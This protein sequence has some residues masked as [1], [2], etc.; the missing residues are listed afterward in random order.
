MQ[1]SP[2]RRLRGRWLNWV[3]R[4]PERTL[5]PAREAGVSGDRACASEVSERSTGA[6]RRSLSGPPDH[7]RL[8]DAAEHGLAPHVA[9][10][11]TAATDTHV[12][13][14]EPPSPTTVGVVAL[15]PVGHRHGAT[16]EA[17]GYLSDLADQCDGL[18]TSVPVVM[19]WCVGAGER[20]E[21]VLT[22]R[23]GAHWGNFVG[24]TTSGAWT[25]T[26]SR[27]QS[28]DLALHEI[29]ARMRKL[30]AAASHRTV[31]GGNT[32][33][34]LHYIDRIAGGRLHIGVLAE[35]LSHA[36]YWHGHDM[37]S[38]AIQDLFPGAYSVADGKVEVASV[39]RAL[40]AVGYGSEI[41]A[42]A[43]LKGRTES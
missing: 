25:H 6:A 19:V 32:Q 1:T 14:D 39:R 3:G 22:N 27:H 36:G 7:I 15:F 42:P 13:V 9:H 30:L 17:M 38:A 4:I 23:E 43:D 24:L 37:V 5:L 10:L 12:L 40:D 35:C 29:D 11:L 41:N 34:A 21:S 8:V 2:W 28:D 18:A 33:R 26:R 20:M 16:P 31:I